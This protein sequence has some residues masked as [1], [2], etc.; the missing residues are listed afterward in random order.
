MGLDAFPFWIQVKL[1]PYREKHKED[2]H[3]LTK[4]NER[5]KKKIFEIQKF[6]LI[7]LSNVAFFKIKLLT[8]HF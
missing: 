8:W 6:I 7:V 3:V 1:G 4:N 2:E 5:N